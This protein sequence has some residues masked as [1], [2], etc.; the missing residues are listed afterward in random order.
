MSDKEIYN[1]IYKEFEKTLFSKLFDLL[2]SDEEKLFK[3]YSVIYTPENL[4]QQVKL[5]K[6][7]ISFQKKFLK[8]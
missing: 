8:K 5:Q 2:K 4:K 6:Y 3:I 7:L 1:L